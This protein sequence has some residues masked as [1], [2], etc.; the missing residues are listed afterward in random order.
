MVSGVFGR[1]TYQ[2]RNSDPYLE[3][4]GNPWLLCSLWLAQYQ[5][6]C[7]KEFG[8]LEPPLA[9]LEKV[10]GAALPR[11]VLAE[12]IDPCRASQRGRRRS[13]GRTGRPY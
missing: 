1:H 7:A 12:Q 11:G 2:L 8:D 3:G 9:I 13:P 5:L 6:L 10:S 4:A